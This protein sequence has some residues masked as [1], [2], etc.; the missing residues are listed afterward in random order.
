MQNQ[1]MPQARRDLVPRL[2]LSL[3]AIALLAAFSQRA[4]QN[5]AR[6]DYRNSNF[7]FFWL[8]GRMAVTGE[9]PYNEAQWLAQHEINHVTW[10]ADPVF[11]YPLPLAVFLAPLGLLP[12]DAAYVCWQL[13]SLAVLAVCCLVGPPGVQHAAP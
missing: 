10:Q 3:S 13:F 4:L 9:D 11:S 1:T 7:V 12:L 2:I 6:I 5:L 8:A